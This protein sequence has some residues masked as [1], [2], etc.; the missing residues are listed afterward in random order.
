[1]KKDEMLKRAF[2]AGAGAALK[3][4]ER[5]PNASESE[6]MSHITKEMKKVIE[7]IK[8]DK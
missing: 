4:T 2:I 8:E 7:E 1:M 5:N 6:I 3:Y